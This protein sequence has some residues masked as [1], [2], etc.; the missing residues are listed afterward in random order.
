METYLYKEKIEKIKQEY[1]K[2]KRK[3]LNIGLLILG[4]ILIIILTF[5]F[6]M[7]KE[8]VSTDCFLAVTI[9]ALVYPT[10]FYIT[11]YSHKKVKF[12]YEEL[13]KL[14]ITILRLETNYDIEKRFTIKEYLNHLYDTR[15]ANR[16][17]SIILKSAFNFEANDLSGEIY[18]VNI[19]KNTGG[20]SYDV[21]NGVVLTYKRET[22]FNFQ[23][24]TDKFSFNK[25]RKVKELSNSMFNVYVEKDVVLGKEQVDLMVYHYLEK[26]KQEFDTIN[27]GIDF[28]E[29]KISFFASS[30]DLIKIP[31]KME[32]NEVIN[33]ASQY[34]KCLHIL[35][36]LNK[37]LENNF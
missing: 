7:L 21:I 34:I 6:L 19:L 30:K 32:V 25:S 26:L 8:L 22:I 11:F 3:L 36:E 4:T 31:K 10:I 15:I 35:E 28:Q 18:A 9:C 37:E 23:A 33:I 5:L 29:D 14:L 13:D 20:S 1:S 27:V 2:L 16:G 12:Y 24:R 17:D